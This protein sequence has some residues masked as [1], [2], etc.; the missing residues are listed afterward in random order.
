MVKYRANLMICGG[1]GCI[2]S[3]GLKIKTALEEE[4]EK[5][6]L[7]DE[8]KIVLTGCNGFCA[9]GP[10]LTV[11]PEGIFYEKLKPE[12]MSLLVE[13]HL[14]KGR[15]V[16]KL[17]Y[18]EPA[19]TH[20]VPVMN[21][22]PFFNL[23]VLRALRNKG[24]IDPERIEDYIARDGY[25]GAA[26]ALT[27]MTPEDVVKT[28]KDSGLRGRGGAGF[29]TG[30]KW[31][32]CSKVAGDVK[33]ILCNGDEGDPGA[34]MDRSIMEA[35][36]H[37]VLEGMIIAAKAIGA[38]HGYIYVRAEYPLAVNRLQ[39]AI[40]QAREM[41]LL[42]K[43]ILGTGF[44]LDIELYL[45][46]GAFVCGEE[47]ALMRSIESKRGMPIPRPP[48]P[49][50]KG[51]WAKPSV[52]NNVETFANVPQII[53][54]GSDWYRSLGTEKSAGTKVFALTGAINNI[55]LIE[56]PMGIP[57]RQIIFDIGGG[58]PRGRKFKAVQLGG[59]SGGCV[60]EH[61]LDTPVTYEDIVNTGAIV[62]SGGM[63]VMD[64]FNCMVSVAKFFLEFTT[65]ESCGKCPPC[66]IGTKVMHDKLVDITEGRGKPGDM[67][68]LEDLSREIIKTSLCGL[69]Q[70]APNPIL[71]T[72]KYF[73]DEYES[74]IHDHWCK[75]GVCTDLVTFYIE[76]ETCKGCGACK[77]VCPSDAISGEK[78]KL[79]TI[80]QALCT[81]CRSCYE[82]CKFGS[83]IA[84]PASLR[85]K[86][87]KEKEP[88]GTASE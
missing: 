70:T 76:E 9:E 24:L 30:L 17:M 26:K 5:R 11:F 43:N 74:H 63:V 2:A 4:L 83:V 66:R 64:N 69:G 42:G 36:P 41:G 6:N 32:L 50:Q 10:I 85:D 28:V 15:P 72:I 3:G 84:G 79:H 12:D 45:G 8:Y 22:I 78:K 21:D 75:A 18:K 34:F 25:Q 7:S 87:L 37:V 55:G 13:E 56:V 39:I 20:K 38:T 46:A 44:D 65:D 29:L 57:L 31:E 48:F 60:P 80:D 53:F 68:V 47:T 77:R 35:D 82:R 67:E 33:Y 49:A 73:A 52:L 86:L 19:K 51:L 71:T 61:L 23:Q 40:D 81:K 1:T 27:E 88:A 14:L 16:E 62:G 58:M 59:P 54:N